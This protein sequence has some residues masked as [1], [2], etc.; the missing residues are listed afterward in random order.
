M[1]IKLFYILLVALLLVPATLAQQAC[2]VT[3]PAGLRLRE[4]PVSGNT[5]TVMPLGALVNVVDYNNHNGWPRVSHG[6]LEGYASA[7]YLSCGGGA[8]QSYNATPASQSSCE[9][10][11]VSIEAND[12]R[13]VRSFN[14]ALLPFV[15]GTWGSIPYNHTTIYMVEAPPPSQATMADG[16]GNSWVVF[17]FAWA[18]MYAAHNNMSTG[19]AI[20]AL[21]DYGGSMCIEGRQF[22]VDASQ[23]FIMTDVYPSLNGGFM[24]IKTSHSTNT[25][26]Y[27]VLTPAS[28]Q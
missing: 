19:I 17:N 14:L 24:Y 9:A 22:T 26:H 12:G 10:G 25:A 7:E 4:L 18:A 20:K 3:A 5:L 2:S 11:Q 6:G 1:K 16:R 15:N 8:E 27:G 23:S 21:I 28:G 13:G